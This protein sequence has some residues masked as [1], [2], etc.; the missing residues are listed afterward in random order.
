MKNLIINAALLLSMGS[1]LAENNW[2]NQ[3]SHYPNSRWLMDSYNANRARWD[4]HYPSEWERRGFSDAWRDPSFADKPEQEY[5][6]GF[7]RSVYS[8]P[9]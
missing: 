7:E 1:I 3:N 2:D 9:K 8:S 5:I 4:F 6:S